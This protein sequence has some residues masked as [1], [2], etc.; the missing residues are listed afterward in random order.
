M[1][2]YDLLLAK[3]LGGDSGG[4]GDITTAEATGTLANPWGDIDFADLKTKLASKDASAYLTIDASALSAGTINSRPSA[5]STE[6]FTNGATVGT[7][8]SNT[9]A[10]G[11]SWSSDGSLYSAKM[12]SGGNIV[13]ISS[14][15]S[16]L[17]TSLFVIYH[18]ISK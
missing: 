1:A 13:D 18:P 16:A 10:Y 9:L 2:F 5:D 3:K 4:G 7:S 6:I 12:L 15:A 11:V 8:A 14:Y 17:T